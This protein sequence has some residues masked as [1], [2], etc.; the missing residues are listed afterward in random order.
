MLRC[1]A[2]KIVKLFGGGSAHGALLCVI[3]NCARILAAGAKH[4][5]L[6]SGSGAGA[7]TARFLC[8]DRSAETLSELGGGKA[9]ELLED[10]GEVTGVRNADCNADRFNGIVGVEQ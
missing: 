6:L 2:L 3:E 4:L 9:D 10:T 8:G 1:K 7:R 5:I